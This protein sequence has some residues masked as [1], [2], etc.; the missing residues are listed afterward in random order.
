MPVS[1]PLVVGR[2]TEWLIPGP[3]PSG[4]GSSHPPNGLLAETV[5]PVSPLMTAPIAKRHPGVNNRH[6]SLTDRPPLPSGEVGHLLV[7]RE[8]FLGAN[9]G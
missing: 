8:A 9:P 7:T 3:G 4:G 2:L 5:V 6:V 1:T